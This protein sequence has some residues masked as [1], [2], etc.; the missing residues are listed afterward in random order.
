MKKHAGWTGPLAILTLVVVLWYWP[1]TL[2]GRLPTE[3]TV[4]LGDLPLYSFFA[5]A[6]DS[7]RVPLW[8]EL[9]GFG[10][11]A[12][13]EGQIGVCYPF[14]RLLFSL[15][16]VSHAFIISLI[17]HTVLAG[18]L[19]SLCARSF[20]QS[21]TAS[22]LVGLVYCGQGFFIT[23]TD[24][25]W[26]WS[27]ACW[28]PLAV[29]A[30]RRWL[31]DGAWAWLVA[32]SGV[33]GLQLLAG[34]FQIAFFTLVILLLTGLLTVLLNPDRRWQLAGRGVLVL[35]AIATGLVLASIQLAPTAELLLHSDLRGRGAEYLQSFSL[36]PV[37]LVLGHLA[38]GCLAQ[39]AATDPTLWVPFRSSAGESLCYVGLLPWALATWSLLACWRERDVR[40]LGLLLAFSLAFSLG[41]F[42]P[43]SDWLLQLPGFDWFPAPARWSVVSGLFWALL[44]GRGLDQIPLEV[45][46][47]WSLRLAFA[48]PT[49]V[50]TG[51]ILITLSVDHDVAPAG[52]ITQLARRLAAMLPRQAPLLMNLCL[53]VLLSSTA[54]QRF[55][56]RRKFWLGL[57]VAWVVVDLGWTGG[58]LRT[59]TWESRG[60][61]MTESPVLKR[62]AKHTGGRVAGD[63]GGL[64]L[65][66]GTGVY[67]NRGIPDMD[68]YWNKWVPSEASLWSSSLSTVPRP[69]RWHDIAIRLQNSLQFMDRDDI[70][71]LRLS[72]VRTLFSAFDSEPLLKN[73]PL[74]SGGEIHD[75]WLTRQYFG[76]NIAHIVRPDSTW[77]VWELDETVVS[78]RAWLFPVDDSP[79]AGSDPRRFRR[80]P[81]ARRRML[82]SAQPLRE[83]VDEGE[84]VVVSGVAGSR[85]VLLLSDL[86]APGWEAELMTGDDSHSVPIDLAFGDWRSVEIPGP[87]R[88]TVTFRYRPESF[89]VGSSISL[90]ALIA[91]SILL[92]ATFWL[93]RE[94]TTRVDG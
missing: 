73:F 29:L 65:I 28:L 18:W 30:T 34:H 68:R 63:L 55:L 66:T 82:E 86:H 75:E 77:L 3:G 27:T 14:H 69:T 11:P 20:G 92:V 85:A 6:M 4:T 31:Q 46:R 48:V 64:P 39:H 33:L 44:A 12:L 74:R 23:Q 51:L 22:L 78:A 72:G 26:A 17:L 2:L 21:R 5:S 91:W 67:T 50:I 79:V 53:L 61:L 1:A 76:S 25:V 45:V 93:E 32:L 80:P 54:L 15:L 52:A 60:D 16:D 70:E 19:A 62:V 49:I 47:R 81:P 87:G 40:L 83:I 13:A 57:A 56:A 36:P 59:M 9:S 8:N 58:L 7:G 41:R 88:F 94:S 42:L 24:H 71:F 10:S 35:L 43:G 38:P 90:I 89:R 84:Q 37:H